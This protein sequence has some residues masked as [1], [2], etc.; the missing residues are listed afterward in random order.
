MAKVSTEGGRP[1]RRKRT[2][3]T[4]LID[5]YTPTNNV[6]E[7]FKGITLFVC[8]KVLLA[9]LLLNGLTH[10]DETLHSCGVQP[11]VHEEEESCSVN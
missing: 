6:L 8:L 9:Q 3:L 11:D 2:Q 7:G 4:N 5:I 10:T 1:Q